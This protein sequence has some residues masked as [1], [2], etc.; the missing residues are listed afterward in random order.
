MKCRL[1]HGDRNYYQPAKIA[2]GSLTGTI[3]SSQVLWF[4]IVI[5]NPSIPSGQ[6]K[7][8]VPFFFYVVD[9]GTAYYTH[10]DV[11]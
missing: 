7:L 4:S 1:F 11:A 8:S 6:N 5:Y 2:C 3:T 10:F 9:Q